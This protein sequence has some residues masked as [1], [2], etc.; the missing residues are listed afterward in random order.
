MSPNEVL[1]LAAR[2][3][4]SLRQSAIEVQQ[5]LDKAQ[6]EML[7]LGAKRQ[8]LEQLK[9]R[10]DTL[11]KELDDVTHRVEVMRV[12]SGVSGRLTIL[13]NGE[14]PIAPLQDRRPMFAAAGGL[15]GGLLPAGMIVLMGMARTRYRYCDEIE[16]DMA[17]QIPVLGMLPLLPSQ[18]DDSEMSTYAAHCVHQIRAMLQNQL[19][20]GQRPI[21]LI[22]SA[23][24]GEGKTSLTAALVLSFAASGCRTLVIDCDMVGRQLTRG[25][26]GESLAGLNEALRAGTIDGYVRETASAGLWVLPVGQGSAM[27]AGTISSGA[28]QR[29]L[30]QARDHFDV[31][32]V[33]SGPILGSVE[34]SVLA[35]QA[36]GVVLVVSRQQLQPMVQRAV[37]RLTAL[38]ARTVGMIFNRAERR[39]FQSVSRSFAM[40]SGSPSGFA[41]QGK[42]W[43]AGDSLTLGPLVSLVATPSSNGKNHDH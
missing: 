36:D 43:Q 38:G 25:Y 2:S 27:D 24:P 40:S 42:R 11:E 21:Y 29:L 31:V 5:L 15:L 3:P 23:S 9:L 12:E 35:P 20:P 32:L 28:V 7:T 22:S 1:A 10:Y 6:A 16:N 34:A 19:E 26:S 41:P 18:L 13:A 37:R 17:Q 33:D 39:D 4:E 30:K 14:T 8:K